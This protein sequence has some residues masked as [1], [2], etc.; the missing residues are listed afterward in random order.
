[1]AD[2]L[3][4]EDS[5]IALLGSE[6]ETE[7]RRRAAET[8]DEWKGVG[9]EEG[10]EIWRIENFSVVKWPKENYGQFY[11]GD[12][13]IVLHSYKESEEKEN[14][15]YNV[16]F[17]LGADTTQDEAGTAAYKTVELDDFLG[18][19]PVQYRE[20]MNHETEEFLKLFEPGI[21]ILDGG[22]DSGFNH[23]E[24]ESYQPVLLHVKG[25]RKN[26][27]VR[28]VPL[29]LASLNDGDV[30]ILDNG[31][32]L[33]QWNGTA[34]G[35]FEKRKAQEV[36][37]QIKED[38]NGR[39]RSVI[40]DGD[41]DHDT[42]WDLLGGKGEVAS[43]EAGGDDAAAAAF[44]KKLFRLSDASGSLE[45]SEVGSGSLSKG[46]LDTSD[47]FIVDTDTGIFVWIGDGTSAD[48]RKNAF[49][50]AN[51]YISKTGK[52]F[53][54]PVIRVTEGSTNAAF[55]AAFA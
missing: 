1:M 13:Y 12:S 40:L 7:A 42:F 50:Y 35:V 36:I 27:A 10:V 17:W 39:P 3:A 52:P 32:E 55:D 15:L 8:A 37:A 25:K 16:H 38:R 4:I 53:H 44:E 48:E 14:L 26:V 47:V 46:D 49:K 29:E 34:S 5:N 23:V 9:E 22:V 31:L 11:S 18:T 41:D 21:R 30:F 24:P 19:L 28:Q 45:M 20:V 6:A 33:I 43:A 51:D 54:T 2:G